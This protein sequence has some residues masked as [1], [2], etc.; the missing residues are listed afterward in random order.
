MS[1]PGSGQSSF[2]PPPETAAADSEENAGVQFQPPREGLTEQA[3]FTAAPE[4]MAGISAELLDAR[5]A[6]EEAIHQQGRPSG[7]QTVEAFASDAGN[8]QGVG[9]GLGEPGGSGVPGAPTLAVFVA[10]QTSA[11][12]VRSVVVDSLGVQAA[13]DLPLSVHRS[14]I[15]DAQPHRFSIR[16]AP[17]GVSVAHR[18]VTAGTIGCLSVGRSAPRN[19]RLMVLSN[20]HVLANSNNAVYGDCICQPGPADGGSCPTHQIAIL[21]RFTPIVFGGGTNYVDC[22]T[23]WC[24]PERVRRELAY[25]SGGAVQ[26]FRIS[27]QPRYPQLGWT[28]GK[29]GRTTQLTAG[30]VTALNWSGWINYGVGYAWFAG[31]FVVQASSGNFSAGGDSGSS[32]WTWDSVR[33]PVG[34]LFAGGGS[35]TICN[36]MPWVVS[37]LDINLY[38]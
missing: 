3:A 30:R 15:I 16:P 1:D 24:W 10:E 25:V 9:I 29:T 13:A 32:V 18:R 34:L 31:Q 5:G 4:A 12:Q 37:A 20:N 11:E 8:I 38:T 2:S 33:Y 21:E 22:A 23:G 19:S 6:L 26:Y 35:Y 14:G 17:G 36:P 27:N 7:V 28:V